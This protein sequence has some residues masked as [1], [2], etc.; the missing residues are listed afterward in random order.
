MTSEATEIALVTGAASG[1]GRAIALRLSDRGAIVG[2]LDLDEDGLKDTRAQIT[3]AGGTADCLVCNVTR[4]DDV[5]RAI[6][7]FVASRGG[8]DTI[9]TAAGVAREGYVHDVTEEDWDLVIDVNLKGTFLIAHHAIPH[10]LTRGC[11]NFVAIGSDAGV[12]GGVGYGIYCASK[13]GV[14]GLVRCMALDYGRKGIRCNIVCPTFVDTPMA[15]E[16]FS[17]APPGIR[18]YYENVVPIGRLARPEEIASAV[19]HLSSA[20][21]S[22]VNGMVYMVDGGATA[23][24]YTGDL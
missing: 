11:G 13:H 24:P 20:E 17:R 21:A 2:L 8:L 6:A 15:E 14:I 4:S 7:G 10:L 19:A 1:I 9:V 12:A 3:G 23:G 22:Y 5:K 18:E 16:I